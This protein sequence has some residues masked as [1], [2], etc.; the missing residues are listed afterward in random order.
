M[1][2]DDRMMMNFK[3]MEGSGSEGGTEENLAIRQSG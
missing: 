3:V 1:G 2:S